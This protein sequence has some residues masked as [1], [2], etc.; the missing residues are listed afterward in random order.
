MAKDFKQ[1]IDEKQGSLR[2]SLAN[3]W[4]VFK[5]DLKRIFT[6]PLLILVFIGALLLPCLYAWLTIYAN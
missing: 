2:A 1:F 3:V 4:S 5:R 6:R